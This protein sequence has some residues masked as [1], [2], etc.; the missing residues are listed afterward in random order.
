MDFNNAAIDCL[1]KKG[2]SL[3]ISVDCGI[4][5]AEEAKYARLIGVDLII[6]DHHECREQTIPDAIAVIDPKQDDCHRY[7]QGSCRRW[8]CSQARVCGRGQKR[9]DSRALCGSCRH[10]HGRGRCR[11]PE[12]T[13]ILSAAALSCS[14]IHRARVLLRCCA[15]PALRKENFILYDRI[16]ARASP[17]CGRPPREVSVA[18]KLLMTHDTKARQKHPRRRTVRAKPPPPAS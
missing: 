14:A 12:R 7:E 2:V 6:T 16:F 5:A 8:C 13:G 3:I 1:H 9:A 10:R 18:G 17:E 4:T 15:S 11:L